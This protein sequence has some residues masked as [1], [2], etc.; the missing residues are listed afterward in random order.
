MPILPFQS[1]LQR[2]RIHTFIHAKCDKRHARHLMAI[3]L[4]HEGRTIT[5]VRYLAAQLDVPSVVGFGGIRM[6]VWGG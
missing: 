1:R 4:L 5:D 2:R 6:K 3:L